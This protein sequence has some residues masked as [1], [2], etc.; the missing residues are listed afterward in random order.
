MHMM[1]YSDYLRQQ[2][3]ECITLA[4]KK[5]WDADAGDLI[6]LA[7]MS[8]RLAATYDNAGSVPASGSSVDAGD[9][10]GLLSAAQRLFSRA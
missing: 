3:S 9:R 6:D 8:R 2:S 7:E 4:V 10:D 5:P 1:T